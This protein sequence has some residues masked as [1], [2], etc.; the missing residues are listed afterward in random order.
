LDEFVSGKARATSYPA[1]S[2]DESRPRRRT[3]P[4]QILCLALSSP[5]DESNHDTVDGEG[6]NNM[7]LTTLKTPKEELSL[8]DPDFS[9]DFD[10]RTELS[11]YQPKKHLN[12]VPMHHFTT[13]YSFS[14]MTENATPTHGDDT[15]DSAAG[16][17]WI[18][19]HPSNHPRRVDCDRS[20]E[21]GASLA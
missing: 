15:R 3:G 5:G 11:R 18:L 17:A 13:A 2:D 9:D 14:S 19:S 4:P 8:V 10:W 16:V 20:G 6:D 7:P 12:G 21:K 1:N